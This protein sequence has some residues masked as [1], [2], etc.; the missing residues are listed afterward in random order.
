MKAATD[1]GDAYSETIN[2]PLVSLATNDTAPSEV[3]IDLLTAEE[4]GKQA[5]IT[6]VKELLA[7]ETTG[8]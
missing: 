2:R 6:N 8:F 4:R 5:V 7:E 3:I 1:D